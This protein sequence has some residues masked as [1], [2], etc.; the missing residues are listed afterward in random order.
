[1]R[2]A[3]LHRWAIAAIVL[4]AAALAWFLHSA[5]AARKPPAAPAGTPVTVMIQVNGILDSMTF[6]EG[7]HARK[8]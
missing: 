1:M 4:L 2:R 8:G 3:R 6:Q 7:Q 5:R